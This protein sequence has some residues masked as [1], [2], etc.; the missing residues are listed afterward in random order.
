M[1]ENSKVQKETKENKPKELDLKSSTLEDSK[2]EKPS[3]EESAKPTKD[4]S[5]K[6]QIVKEVISA[7]VLLSSFSDITSFTI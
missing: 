1:E 2:P 7:L 4:E 6:S 5:S 3:R